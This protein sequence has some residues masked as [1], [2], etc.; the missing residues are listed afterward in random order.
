MVCK[1]GAQCSGS[2]DSGFVSLLG[3]PNAEFG[4]ASIQQPEGAC[5]IG[6]ADNTTHTVFVSHKSRT[7]RGG[8][9][10]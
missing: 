8:D 10:F 1:R 3:V 5:I 7:N 4:A 9:A 2:S 6:V